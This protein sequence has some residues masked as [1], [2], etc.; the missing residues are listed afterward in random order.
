MSAS[1]KIND[2]EATL[3]HAP[4][5]EATSQSVVVLLQKIQEK[6]GYLPKEE[7]VSLAKKLHI[8]SVDI[9]GV[10]TFYSQFKLSAKGKHVCS[11]CT[12]TA[13]HIKACTA[14]IEAVEKKY[15]VKK[16]TTT[17]DGNLTLESVNCIGAC[18]KAPAVMLDGE[19]LGDVTPA[20]LLRA[21]EDLE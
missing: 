1:E 15:S 13:C 8:P 14:L 12:G 2:C 11:V 21:L 19:V 4:L 6:H 20:S 7:L 3:N 17:A 5:P 10:A 18:A 16:N 9:F